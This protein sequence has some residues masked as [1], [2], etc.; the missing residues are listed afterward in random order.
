MFVDISRLLD[1]ASATPK[2]LAEFLRAEIRNKTKCN[3]SAGMGMSSAFTL[4][5]M[6]LGL[7]SNAPSKGAKQVPGST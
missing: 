5:S 1:E 7:W 4:K 2:E 3:A 6:N